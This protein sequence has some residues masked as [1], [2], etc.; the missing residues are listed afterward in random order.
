MHAQYVGWTSVPALHAYTAAHAK[1]V[2]RPKY[3]FIVLQGCFK[4]ENIKMKQ[5][6]DSVITEQDINYLKSL[7]VEAL[8][9]IDSVICSHTTGHWKKIAMVISKSYRELEGK[10]PKLTYEQLLSR[11]HHLINSGKLSSQG[12][13]NVMRFSEVKRP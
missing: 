6:I 10:D 9:A 3:L 1:G 11:L 4:G 13:I 7:S 8:S 12:N 5:P 2:S